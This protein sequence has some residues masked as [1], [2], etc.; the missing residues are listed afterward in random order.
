MPTRRINVSCTEPD[1]VTAAFAGTP[2]IACGGADADMAIR[3]L[4]EH[5]FDEVG[6]LCCYHEVGEENGRTT[7]E[8]TVPA[9]SLSEALREVQKLFPDAKSVSLASSHFCPDFED[10]GFMTCICG[11]RV[12]MHHEEVSKPLKY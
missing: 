1:H 8:A 6:V 4:L 2:Q 5:Y 11:K 12:V 7:F 9:L 10:Y 3:R